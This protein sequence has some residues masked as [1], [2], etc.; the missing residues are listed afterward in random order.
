MIADFYKWPIVNYQ[1]A[2]GL[3]VLTLLTLSI[4][5]VKLYLARRPERFEAPL[6]KSIAG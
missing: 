3:M 6:L 5:T 4:L 2:F 1:A